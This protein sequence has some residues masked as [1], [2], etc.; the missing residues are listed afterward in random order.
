MTSS[1]LRIARQGKNGWLRYIA[2]LLLIFTLA[3]IAVAPII[4]GF[5]LTS[6]TSLED[7]DSQQLI[8]DL[9]GGNPLMGYGF[10]GFTAIVLTAALYLAVTRIHE[11]PFLTL[12]SPDT[13]IHWQ[14]TLKGFGLWLGLWI[15]SFALRYVISPGSYHFSFNASEWLPFALLALLFIPVVST[16]HV[17]FIYGYLFQG[18]GLIIG[19]PVILSIVAVVILVGLPPGLANPGWM[20]INM[21]YAIGLFWVVIRDNRAEL[22]MGITLAHQLINLLLVSFPHVDVTLPSVTLFTVDRLPPVWWAFLSLSIR[23][24]IFYLVLLRS[25]P[26]PLT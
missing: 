8:T 15:F 9:I 21:L 10:I 3:I 13:A 16:V 22:V 14:R 4:I 6:G 23:A 11:R 17:L 5:M 25:S 26:R 24:G 1:F 20:I 12:I 18:I 19:N 2:S 7:L